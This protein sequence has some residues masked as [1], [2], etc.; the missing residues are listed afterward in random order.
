MPIAEVENLNAV[1][2]AKLSNYESVI[3]RG[4]R[5]VFEVARA[6]REIRDGRLF[7]ASHATFEEYCEE[8]WQFKRSR[9]AQL[10]GFYRVLENVCGVT[11]VNNAGELPEGAPE[12]ERF[13]RELQRLPGDQQSEAWQQILQLSED[14]KPTLTL[15]KAVVDRWLAGDSRGT[16]DVVGGHTCFDAPPERVERVEPLRQP[17]ERDSAAE[18]DRIAESTALAL[19]RAWAA[20]PFAGRMKWLALTGAVLEE[21]SGSMGDSEVEPDS[22]PTEEA[23]A[24]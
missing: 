10:I 1:E 13:T 14:G 6:L 15:V 20:V 16:P 18:T 21:F 22:E 12:N 4:R 19:R 11:A 17:S 7:R 9:A 5:Q 3:E 24:D 2:S 23:E 8:R